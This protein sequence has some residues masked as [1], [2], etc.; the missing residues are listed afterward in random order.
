MQF[1]TATKSTEELSKV[2][3]NLEII[4]PENVKK[5]I[6]DEE[7]DGEFMWMLVVIFEPGLGENTIC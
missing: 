4:K 7:F 2:F 5:T 1:N 3:T 6:I